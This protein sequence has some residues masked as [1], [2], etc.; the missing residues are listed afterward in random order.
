[1]EADV[2]SPEL[3]ADYAYQFYGIVGAQEY[4]GCEKSCEALRA[5]SRSGSTSTTRRWRSSPPRRSPGSSSSRLTLLVP[6]VHKATVDQFGSKWTEFFNIVTNGPFKLES[7]QH[8]NSID[9]VKNEE[10]VTPTAS[11]SRA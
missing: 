1:M 5:W 3:A 11:R 2:I 10:G 8:N 6:V 9:L 7:W 4:N